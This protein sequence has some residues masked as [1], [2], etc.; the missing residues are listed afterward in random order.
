MS[1]FQ[2]VQS[3]ESILEKGLKWHNWGLNGITGM[4]STN[5]LL[6]LLAPSNNDN[7]TFTAD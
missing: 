6:L 2:N 1:T 7:L 3:L 4:L 5:H